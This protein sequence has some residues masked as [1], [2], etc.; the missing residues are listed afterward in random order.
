MGSPWCE[1]GRAKT[2]N[3]PVQVTLTHAVRIGQFEVTQREW[4]NL[5]LPNPSG[6]LPDGTGDC[7][8]DECP[9]GNVTWVEA[10]AF[11]NLVSLHEG[12]PEC[13]LLEGCTGE[14]G[15]GMRCSSVR[16]VTRSIYDCR[17]YRLPTGVEWEYAARAGTK[18]AYYAGDIPAGLEY[19]NCKVDPDLEAIAWYCANAGG[20]THPV[21][22]RKPNAWGIYD[23]IGNAFE[24][25]GSIVPPSE[26][27]PHGPF[28]DLGASFEV[29][30]LLDGPDV[31][32]ERYG[33]NRGGY[34]RSRHVQLRVSASLTFHPQ[35]TYP[36]YGLRLA[37]TVL[38]PSGARR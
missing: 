1:N 17:G 10:L 26:G 11:T 2:R 34:Y 19:S 35:F 29:S 14:M 30:G 28:R 13:Y 36:G 24:W 7:I 20:A 37:R 3:D 21:G 18:T 38:A 16:S 32:V 22:G 33:Q 5:G 12:L 25:V 4:I 15:R 23:M 8:G 27:Y 31:P 6:Q 9:V